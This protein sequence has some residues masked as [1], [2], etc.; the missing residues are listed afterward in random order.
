MSNRLIIL[1]FICIAHYGLAQNFTLKLE[2]ANCPVSEVY[3]ADYYGDKNNILDTA[4]IDTTGLASFTLLPSYPSGMYKIILDQQAFLDIIYNKE[5]IHLITDYNDMYES[6][7]FEKSLENQLYYD[8][9][10]SRHEFRRKFDL[11]ASLNDFYPPTDSFFHVA[12]G[13]YIGIQADMQVYI[14]DIIELYPDAWTT[15]IIKFQRPLYYDPSMDDVARRAYRIEHYFDNRKF[16]DLELIRSNVYTSSAIEYMTFYSNPNFTQEQLESEF[17]KAVD[18]VMYEAMDNSLIY[19][20]IV[21]YLVGGFEHYHFEKVLDYIA[22][23]YTPEQC[24]NEDLKS[25]LQTRLQKY[26]ELAVGQEAPNILIKDLEGKEVNLSKIKSDYTLIIFWASW[27]PHCNTMLPEIHNIYQSSI[28]PKK[29]SI[30]SISLDTK[31]EEWVTALNEGQYTW[32]N[33]S[34]L[35]GWESQCAIDYNIYATPTMILM[36]KDKSI[37]AKPITLEELKQALF[38]ENILK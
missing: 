18:K 11:L 30:L 7:E 13:Q 10:R 29:M 9:L 15:K 8:F 38:K 2:V 35:K 25:D 21:E 12:R 22:L 14:N 36:D 34:E 32:I 27:C 19:D 16:T 26:A 28:N 17:I 37:L 3:L 5:D 1:F 33:A 20:F 31:K 24:E 23:N 6:L 4:S